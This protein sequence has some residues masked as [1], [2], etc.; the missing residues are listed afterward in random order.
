LVLPQRHPL[1]VGADELQIQLRLTVVT[2]S[3]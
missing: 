2:V 1:V 3:Q